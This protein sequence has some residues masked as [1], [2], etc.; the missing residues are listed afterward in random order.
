MEQ[1]FP[2]H[3]EKILQYLTPKCLGKI[4]DYS[5]IVL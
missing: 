3:S 4:F 1:C 2:G 5:N